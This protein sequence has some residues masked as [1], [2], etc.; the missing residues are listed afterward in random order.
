MIYIKNKNGIIKLGYTTQV[1]FTVRLHKFEVNINDL[2][3]MSSDN[4]ITLSSDSSKTWNE[5][6]E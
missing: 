2:I 4:V 5:K 1:G 6:E 3:K